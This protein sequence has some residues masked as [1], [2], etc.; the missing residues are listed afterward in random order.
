MQ[1]ESELV[2]GR[3]IS[4]EAHLRV[5]E[6]LLVEG[7]GT[8]SRA[9]LRGGQ[10]GLCVQCGLHA[11]RVATDPC[12]RASATCAWM[13]RV[14]HEGGQLHCRLRAAGCRLQVVGCNVASTGRRGDWQPC[15]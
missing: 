2:V 9:A 5:L 10:E 6:V 1:M 8:W 3:Q 15:E 12:E 11:R 13:G 4:V 14:R 7:L